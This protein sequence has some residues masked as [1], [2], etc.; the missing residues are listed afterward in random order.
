[1]FSKISRYKKL[2][3]VVATDSKGH[4]PRSKA[5]RLVP[6]VSGDFYHT[7]EETDRLDHL[8]YKY[9]RQPRKFWRIS[10]ANPEFPSP[11]ALLGKAPVASVRFPLAWDDTAGQP[12]WAELRHRMLEMVGVMDLQVIEETQLKPRLETVDSRPVTVHA[13][14]Y[15][16]AVIVTHNQM[17]VTVEALAEA[18]AALGFDVREPLSI[19]RIGKRIIIPQNTAG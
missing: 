7:V 15:Q 9:Y 14:Q 6:E 18:I 4:L 3:D 2:T 1:M 17:N 16:R 12:P 11:S 19:G 8:A 5:L 13:T 10:D